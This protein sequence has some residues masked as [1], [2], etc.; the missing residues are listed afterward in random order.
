[1]RF[2]WSVK[3]LAVVLVFL[4]ALTLTLGA[5][6]V[7]IGSAFYQDGSQTDYDFDGNLAGNAAEN[8]IGTY[9][10]EN[11]SI[12]AEYFETYAD[13]WGF[14]PVPVEF[15]YY[16]QFP[17]GRIV[18]TFDRQKDYV[19]EHETRR[20][21]NRLTLR[22]MPEL[23]HYPT[24]DQYLQ[25]GSQ[26][27][28]L[29]PDFPA[30][31]SDTESYVLLEQQDGSVQRLEVGP[32]ETY[33]VILYATAEQ[34]E[35]YRL[36][37][38]GSQAIFR[39]TREYEAVFQLT[40]IVSVC[41]LL[42]SL[43]AMTTIAGCKGGT[44]EIQPIWINRL[45]LDLHLAV[46]GGGMTLVVAMVTAMVYEAHRLSQDMVMLWTMALVGLGLAGGLLLAVFFPAVGS[47]GKMG[48]GYWWKHMLTVRFTRFFILK[49]C[50]W[51]G[52]N[53]WRLL[54]R[55]I[56]L[57]PL[58]LEWL[59]LG[60]IAWLLGPVGI[61][62]PVWM[63]YCFSE[64][65]DAA[66]RMAEGD[67]NAKVELSNPVL[68]GSFR[69]FARNLND[70][71]AVC[72][73]SA[74]SQMRSERMR[75]ELITNVSHDIKTPLTSIINYVDLLEKAETPE[76]RREYIQVLQ[77]QSLR[78]KRL[79]EDLME[80]S[81]A[82][83]GN[84]CVELE[85]TDAVE[86]IGQAIGEFSDRLEAQNLQV[87]MELPQDAVMVLCDGRLLWRV[88]SNCLTN[89]VKYALPG[90][91]VYLSLTQPGAQARITLKNISAQPLNI[92][93]D[94]LLER[95]VRGDASR[96]TEG[97]GLGLNI[98]RSLMEVQGG[99][100]ELV[101]DGDLFKVVLTLPVAP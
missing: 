95:F 67:L 76:Q 7:V 37:Y 87:V 98:A 9:L 11:S 99:H 25:A 2:H 51:L 52:K 66:Q 93:G 73:E 31:L 75:S 47:Q 64:L 58:W 5:V 20:R 27:S 97:N 29:W 12:P 17:T 6:G 71:S 63:A 8:I 74:K 77:R 83:S 39:L 4:S 1:M 18:T 35:P 50:L 41:V 92:P 32:K 72:V 14:S 28:T 85:P 65:R 26:V 30:L 70:L 16:I 62:I 89:V 57:V 78:M 54:G 21:V 94:E 23:S 80:M 90:T 68:R 82:S 19:Y 59:V 53:G 42:G 96:N 84:L 49:P 24:Y 36:S 91:R 101:V 56:S 48:G 45:P 69:S 38:P 22:T 3:T 81:K 100:L 60:V 44:G 40:T 61:L 46:F 34:M 79:I 10:V 86:S 15:D 88:L 33:Q 13:W 43:C 55:W